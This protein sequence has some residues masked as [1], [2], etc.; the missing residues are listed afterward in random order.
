[1]VFNRIFSHSADQR[2]EPLDQ[3]VRFRQQEV[4]IN[5]AGFDRKCDSDG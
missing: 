4:R 3:T 5:I 1:M 2:G